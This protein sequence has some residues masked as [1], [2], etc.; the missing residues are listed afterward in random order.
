V[1]IPIDIVWMIAVVFSVLLWLSIAAIFLLA[2]AAVPFSLIHEK[3]MRLRAATF[4]CIC[5]GGCLG[6]ESIQRAEKQRKELYKQSHRD[7][8][9]GGLFAIFH[10]VC[11]C[12][13]LYQFDN[14]KRDFALSAPCPTSAQPR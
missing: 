8:M 13:A 7:G 4:K 3:R 5:C 12:G 2:I 9:V 6:V 1:G 10:A 11:A 14:V